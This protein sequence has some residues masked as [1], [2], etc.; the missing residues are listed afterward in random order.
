MYTYIQVPGICVC[1]CV[2][3][4]MRER[5]LGGGG[6]SGRLNF[7]KQTELRPLGK[8]RVAALCT[9]PREDKSV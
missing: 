8:L 4:E 5:A 7:T 1:V 9:L 3:I 2:Y 6:R